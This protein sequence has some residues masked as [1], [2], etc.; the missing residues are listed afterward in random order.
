MSNK[1]DNPGH[2]LAE[3][4]R[5]RLVSAALV[6]GAA[7]CA[8]LE[9][10]D[11]AWAQTVDSLR[12]AAGGDG[13]RRDHKFFNHSAEDELHILFIRDLLYRRLNQRL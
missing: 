7:S 8:V 9:E 13:W 11:V 2:F 12:P 5:R 6:C 3:F 1:S 4:R 10:A